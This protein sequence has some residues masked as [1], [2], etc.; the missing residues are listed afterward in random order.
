MIFVITDIC[1]AIFLAAKINSLAMHKS[2][3]S[4][5]LAIYNFDLFKSL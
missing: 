5:I 4:K 3:E 1:L 2:Y